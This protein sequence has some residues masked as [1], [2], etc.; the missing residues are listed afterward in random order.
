VFSWSDRS[1]PPVE[2]P[3]T[4]KESQNEEYNNPY[5]Q[6]SAQER[7]S[8]AHVSLSFTTLQKKHQCASKRRQRTF[9][10]QH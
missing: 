5:P 9:S 7:K 3:T 6:E 4:K 2:E 10:E 8:F 1:T